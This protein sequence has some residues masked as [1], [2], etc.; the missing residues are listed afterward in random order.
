MSAPASW[1][2]SAEKDFGQTDHR[3]QQGR[4]R[5]PD[6]LHRNRP[7]QAGRLHAGLPQPAR[8][9]HHHARSRA[10]GRLHHRQ[11]HP[12]REPGARSRLHLGQGRQPLQD[13][14]RPRRRGEEEPGQDQRL[15]HRHPE[16]RPSR[17]PD[18]CRRRP[19]VEFRIV[20]FDGGAQQ[21]TGVL[22][23][24]VDVAFDNVGSVFK[25]VRHGRDPRAGRHRHRALE[26]PAADAHHQGA[27][28]CRR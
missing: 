19:S 18:D 2:A 8:H 15:H 21:L 16:R 12:D 25:R 26:V 28:L 4:R 23:G 14:G 7:R 13:A 10:Q 11:L 24:H 17:H 9:E 6:R 3:G 5:R 20:H 22:G 27:G 1:P